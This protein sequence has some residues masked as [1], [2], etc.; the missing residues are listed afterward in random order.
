MSTD[1]IEKELVTETPEM[2]PPPTEFGEYNI[3]SR[4]HISLFGDDQLV[5]VWWRGTVF[6][7]CPACF[8]VPRNMAWSDFITNMVTPWASKDPDFDV[9][10]MSAWKM[11]DEP[12]EPKDD[13]TIEGLGIEHKGLVSFEL[14]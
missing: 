3:P 5:N 1:F 7:V 12:F 11:D 10:R 6:N 14:S 13:D 8:R 9:S 2:A 4:D